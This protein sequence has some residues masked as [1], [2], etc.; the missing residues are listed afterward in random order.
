MYYLYKYQQEIGIIA[1]ASVFFSV[2][3]C[4][5]YRPQH[6]AIENMCNQIRRSI[7][8]VPEDEIQVTLFLEQSGLRTF[9][10]YIRNI[11]IILFHRQYW[12][13]KLI[14]CFVKNKF[15]NIGK[16]Y[17]RKME[18]SC[19][20]SYAR[21]IMYFQKTYN[22]EQCHG[23]MSYYMTHYEKAKVNIET[24]PEFSPLKERFDYSNNQQKRYD[25][26]LREMKLSEHELRCFNR[27]ANFIHV[28]PINNREN[29]PIGALVIDIA[30]S[31]KV[32]ENDNYD[33]FIACQAMMIQI[34]ENY[35]K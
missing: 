4:L 29:I 16:K 7:S 23:F 30:H 32:K 14:Y 17:Y 33:E 6:E 8:F 27:A 35:I 10:V 24:L 12:N 22:N 25:K 28:I 13:K 19:S 5:K 3:L 21:P 34:V 20:S 31:T 18:Q 26:Y 1:V 2:L 9:F 11:F 15:P